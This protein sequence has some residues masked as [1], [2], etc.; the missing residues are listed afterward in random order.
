MANCLTTSETANTAWAGRGC[1]PNWERLKTIKRYRMECQLVGFCGGTP[2]ANLKTWE[3]GLLTAHAIVLQQSFIGSQ[4]LSLFPGLGSLHGCE[5]IMEAIFAQPTFLPK[6][7]LLGIDK[8]GDPVASIQAMEGLGEGLIMNVGV[9]PHARGQGWGKLI[10]RQCLEAMS[11]DGVKFASLEVTGGNKAAIH[12]YSGIGF[13]KTRVQ[14]LP[15]QENPL[16][17]KFGFWE[18]PLNLW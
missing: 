12:L 17:S 6:A 15:L 4:D 11:V 8:N 5:A 1:H 18:L 13:C 10:I 14:Y 3:P 16:T 7:T 2:A 9:V